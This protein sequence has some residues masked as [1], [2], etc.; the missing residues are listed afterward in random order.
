M[1]KQN[2]FSFYD[3]SFKEITEKLKNYYDIN[4]ELV[5]KKVPNM[6]YTGK[7]R[8]EDGFEHILKVL[9]LDY[10]FEYEYIDSLKTVIIK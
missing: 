7:F 4:I 9:K 3:N 8:T 2:I 10:P 1:W 5:N 6:R